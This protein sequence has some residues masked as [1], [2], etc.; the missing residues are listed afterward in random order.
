MLF[1]LRRGLGFAVA[2]LLPFSVLVAQDASNSIKVEWTKIDASAD[3]GFR[4]MSTVGKNIVWVSGSRG[5]VLRSINGGKTF[6]NVSVPDSEKLDFR[7]VHAFDKDNAVVMNAGFPGVF[8][9]TSDGGKSWKKVYDDQREKIFFGAMDFWDQKNGVAFGDPIDGRMVILLTNDG[10]NRWKEIDQS[11][12]P[13]M[14]EG[15]AGFAASGTCLVAGGKASI[16][17]AT[18]GG[19]E[20]QDLSKSKIITSYDRGKS[21]KN[22]EV[23][24]PRGPS[25]GMFSL[26]AMNAKEMV[27]VGGDYRK[28]D[29]V[30]GNC[31]LTRDGGKT[32]RA[33]K[34]QNPSGFRS[35]VAFNGSQKKPV[36]IA[37][38]TNGVD[39][40]LDSGA[41]WKRID[42][43]PS[44]VIQFSSDGKTIYSAGPKGSLFVGRIVE[45]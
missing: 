45:K 39:L 10:G 18:G 43:H 14:E 8:F 37:S 32:W 26:V 33:I 36:L 5:T 41:T 38:G 35:C 13:K 2:C 21:W 27:A 1:N 15:Q 19:T 29:D 30:K 23:P 3:V 40:S 20:E 11:S 16:L 42:Q 7:D 25:A 17:V 34:K 9:R 12:Q 24:I 31:A 22:L 4:G 28:P 6:E 44:N